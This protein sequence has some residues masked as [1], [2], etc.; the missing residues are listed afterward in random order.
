M[1]NKRSGGSILQ[2][3]I[4]HTFK[5]WN[6]SPNIKK[7]SKNTHFWG[8]LNRQN[9]LSMT[10]VICWQSLRLYK[11]GKNDWKWTLRMKS[12]FIGDWIHQCCSVHWGGS[13]QSPSKTPPPSFLTIPLL[14]LQ[15]VQVN[16]VNWIFPWYSNFSSLHHP[17]F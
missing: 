8:L 11:W 1:K 12:V 14:N 3:F 6:T 16:F 7:N 2:I 4:R 17:I 10:R 9:L 13:Y 15:T 5:T